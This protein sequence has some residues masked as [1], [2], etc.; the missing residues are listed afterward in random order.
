MQ[1]I[2]E[3]H[4]TYFFAAIV[5]IMTAVGLR[6]AGTPSP[7]PAAIALYV[8]GV[9]AWPVLREKLPTLKPALYAA[10]WASAALVVIV[11]ETLGAYAGR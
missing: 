5:A 6:L 3:N 9:V 7:W 1:A 10:I 8:Y 2:T 11:Y 4:P